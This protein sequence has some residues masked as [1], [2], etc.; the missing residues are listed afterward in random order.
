MTPRALDLGALW[1]D[2][3]RTM[4]VWLTPQTDGVVTATMPSGVPFRIKRIASY[5]GTY[6]ATGHLGIVGRSAA[7]AR[8]ETGWA[9]WSTTDPTLHSYQCKGLGCASAL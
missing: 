9:T 5:D 2:E 1:G 4:G 8:M 7:D 6:M 3:R